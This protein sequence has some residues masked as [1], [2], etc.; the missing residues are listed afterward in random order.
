MDKAEMN[1]SKVP[2]ECQES[3]ETNG[4]SSLMKQENGLDQLGRNTLN[5]R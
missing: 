5:F 1:V 2:A 3:D 4:L